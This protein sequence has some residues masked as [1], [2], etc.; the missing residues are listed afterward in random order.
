M[1]IVSF[2]SPH[3]MLIYMADNFTNLWNLLSQGSF[4]YL[5]ILI[6]NVY[7]TL[8]IKDSQ[9]MI[10]ELND[11]DDVDNVSYNLL[12][13]QIPVPPTECRD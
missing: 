1:I 13:F 4:I 3:S 2:F 9:V 7:Y 5:F 8:S 12:T 11:D 6:T 10:F